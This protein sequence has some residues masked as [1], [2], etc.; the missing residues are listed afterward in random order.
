M[1]NNISWA[2]Y[3][4]IVFI[5]VSVY[6]V[7]VLSVYFKSEIKGLF[8]K[9]FSLQKVYSVQGNKTLNDIKSEQQSGLFFEQGTSL[10]KTNE[11][12]T[13]AQIFSIVQAAMDELQA[14]L[15][16]VMHSR[17]LKKEMVFALQ[18]ILHKY[19]ALNGSVYQESLNHFIATECE[20]K[21]SIHLGA[22]EIC[23]LWRR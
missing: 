5:L 21:C 16:E 19:P 23:Q 2:S 20:N 3:W 13:D 6:Y 11:G 22:E 12:A 8:S 1:I 18:Q 9:G 17:V 4:S 7:I 10:A 14:Y 15:Q